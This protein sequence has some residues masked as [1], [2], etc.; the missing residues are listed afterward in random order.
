M[1]KVTVKKGR[2]SRMKS[3]KELLRDVKKAGSRLKKR[4][5]GK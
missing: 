2:K 1:T 5:T 4:A 3:A